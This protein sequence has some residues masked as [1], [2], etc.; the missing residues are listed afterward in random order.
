MSNVVQKGVR[1]SPRVERR[2][3]LYEKRVG[4]MMGTADDADAPDAP[5]APDARRENC[6]S[7][8]CKSSGQSR[9]GV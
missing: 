9:A 4:Q 2:D 3:S 7:A 1:G 5:D 6:A 8:A